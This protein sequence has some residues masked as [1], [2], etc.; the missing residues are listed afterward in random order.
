MS[1][2]DLARAILKGFP[3]PARL[4]HDVMQG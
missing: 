2:K 4:D 1:P 3:E